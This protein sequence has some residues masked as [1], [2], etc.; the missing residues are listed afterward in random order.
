MH[1]KEKYMHDSLCLYLTAA[2]VIEKLGKVYQWYF[3]LPVT[4]KRK[5]SFGY[6]TNHWRPFS[7]AQT[8]V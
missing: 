1:A 5:M 7:I 6:E 3:P 8:K 2:S 4:G